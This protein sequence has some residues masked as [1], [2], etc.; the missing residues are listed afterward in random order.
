MT[1]VKFNEEKK[2]LYIFANEEKERFSSVAMSNL[3]NLFIATT[4]MNLQM[5]STPQKQ[6]RNSNK[7]YFR[8]N[9]NRG[10][11]IDHAEFNTDGV[12]SFESWIVKTQITISQMNLV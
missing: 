3:T 8:T 5:Y 1:L 4:F 11:N 7:I 6:L 2:R 9:A 10:T 12:V